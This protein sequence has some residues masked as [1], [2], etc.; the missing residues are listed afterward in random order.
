[1]AAGSRQCQRQERPPRRSAE[2]AA[3]L[4]DGGKGRAV[5]E[6][7][8]RDEKEQTARQQVMVWG[9]CPP[10][11]HAKRLA[12]ARQR[13]AHSRT[14][15]VCCVLLPIPALMVSPTLHLEDVPASARTLRLWTAGAI[16]LTML[17]DFE[18]GVVRAVP[19]PA[20]LLIDAMAGPALAAAPWLL[21]SARGL[22]AL[23]ASCARWRHGAPPCPD[24]QDAAVGSGNGPGR[25]DHR[26]DST[27][28]EHGQH[29][30]AALGR[31]HVCLQAVPTLSLGYL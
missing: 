12:R 29:A 10:G 17:T 15:T 20:H 18:L 11:S 25:S 13:A 5:P 6:S 24:H 27:R 19:M 31:L 7:E 2:P 21:G 1:M 28:Q 4:T 9:G 14:P 3:S 30:G 22:A 23:A 26:P 16:G 8:G